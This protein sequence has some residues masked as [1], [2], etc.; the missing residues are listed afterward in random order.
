MTTTLRLRAVLGVNKTRINPLIARAQGMHDG[1]AAD[2]ATYSAPIPTL[3]AFQTLI[4]NLSAAQ[5]EVATRVK[6]A[7]AMRTVQRNILFTAMGTELMYIQSIADAF[8]SRAE[9]I[10]V[11]GGLV[12]A[13]TAVHTKAIIVL[14]L[15]KQPGTV[16]CNAN[17]GLLV[18]TGTTKPS[19][20][21]F[22]NWGYTLDG[23]T[24]IAMPSTSTGK[25]TIQ[26]LPLLTTVGVRVNLNNS[27]GPG[28]W[29]QVVTILVH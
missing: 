17:V 24:F 3:A 5:Q 29:S 22:F 9:A 2:T 7:V 13:Q 26:N 4:Q 6:G 28:E 14:G 12:V 25:T 15:T 1:M 23:K 19:Q 20:S 18:G 27:E 11:N 8:P 10:I 21:R 16:T